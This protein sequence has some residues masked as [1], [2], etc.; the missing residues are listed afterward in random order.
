MAPVIVPTT[1]FNDQ[2]PGTSGLRKKV[3]VYSQP[4][5]VANFIQSIFDVMEGIQGQTVVVGGDGRFYNPEAIQI[6]VRMAAANGIGRLLIGRGGILSTP[7]RF[8]RHPQVQGVRRHHPVGQPQPGRPRRRFRH[9]VQY[10]QRRP[11]AGADHRRDIQA[12]RRDLRIPD[13]GN[14]GYRPRPAG[15]DRGGHDGRDHRSGR[16]LCRV[17]GKPVRLRPD[18]VAV[19]GRQ[20]PHGVRRAQRRHRPLCDGDPGKAPGRSG[21]DRAERDAPARLRRP[22]PGPQPGPRP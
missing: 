15:H 11:G 19:P 6:I 2:K 17:D 20:V 22:S 10:R 3:T 8:Q 7:G 1:P 4:H 13:A 16:R 12:D 21:G 9:Q 14:P 5:Y 18:P